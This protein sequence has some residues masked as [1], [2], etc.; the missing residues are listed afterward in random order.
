MVR[1]LTIKRLEKLCEEYD[2][3]KGLYPENAEE[4]WS[5]C[6]FIKE[7]LNCNTGNKKIKPKKKSLETPKPIIISGG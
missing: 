1:L 5:V 2:D 6:E 3:G 4:G 7:R